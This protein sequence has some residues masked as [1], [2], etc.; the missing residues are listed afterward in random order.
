ML[1]TLY[2]PRGVIENLEGVSSSAASASAA[3]SASPVLS[4]T[5]GASCDASATV[6]RLRNS[7]GAGAAVSAAVASLVASP[8]LNAASRSESN[9]SASLEAT[10]ALF[11]SSSAAA[12]AVA[13][14]KKF[15]G[16]KSSAN[17]VIY[18]TK[19]ILDK[20]KTSVDQ[21]IVYLRIDVLLWQFSTSKW[22]L[23]IN[24]I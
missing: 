23:F 16:L 9:A 14:G 8:L 12:N 4:G 24:V 20:F 22:R 15:N 5:S 18:D 17:A 21:N 3:L 10:V 11:A 6:E 7:A 2:A 1:L 13:V 19:A